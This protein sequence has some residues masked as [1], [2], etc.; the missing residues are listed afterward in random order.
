MGLFPWPCGS[1]RNTETASL[2]HRHRLIGKALPELTRN[3]IFKC[4]KA[5]EVIKFTLEKSEK[6]RRLEQLLS[7][8]TGQIVNALKFDF[9]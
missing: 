4:P 3:L 6:I 7:S 5:F 2:D 9:Q 8:L 1:L